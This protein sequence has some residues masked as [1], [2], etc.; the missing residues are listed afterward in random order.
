MAAC[1][2]KFPTCMSCASAIGVCAVALLCKPRRSDHGR[3]CHQSGSAK[4]DDHDSLCSTLQSILA[5][6]YMIVGT[7]GRVVGRASVGCT[8]AARVNV[9]KRRRVTRSGYAFH[10]AGAIVCGVSMYVCICFVRLAMGSVA[11]DDVLMAAVSESRWRRRCR[12][13][14]ARTPAA[15]R[16]FTTDR[17]ASFF[18]VEPMRSE[19]IVHVRV[20][21]VRVRVEVNC[22]EVIKSTTEPIRS[23]KRD[24][25]SAGNHR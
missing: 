1:A 23:T 10:A 19:S 4:T 22:G 2:Y 6:P 8:A 17:N 11:H 20:D 18:F 14:P 16:N 24:E 3:C 15:M 12:F 9:A 7:V 13:T 25:S 5:P 21:V